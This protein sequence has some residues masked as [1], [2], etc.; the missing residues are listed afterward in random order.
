ML[1]DSKELKKVCKIKRLPSKMRFEFDDEKLILKI[2]VEKRSVSE[3][4][5]NNSAAFEGWIFC[6]L[7]K[8]GIEKVKV[9]ELDWEKPEEEKNEHYRRF[10]YRVMKMQNHFPW[11]KIAEQ[12][13]V[14]VDSFRK[15]YYDCGKLYL[16]E[17]DSHDQKKVKKES[18]SY[19]EQVFYEKDGLKNKYGLEVV[20][21]QLPV[22]VFKDHI[23][24]A[25]YVFT[26]GKSAID[27]W[28]IKGKDLYI[29]ELKYNNKMVGIISE[30]L[31]Y[32]WIMEDVMFTKKMKYEDKAKNND[33]RKFQN[34]YSSIG[35]IS[36]IYAVFLID[37]LHPLIDEK[38]I[39]II[40]RENIEKRQS[41]QICKYKPTTDIEFI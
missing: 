33:K 3:N 19:M 25:T 2:V 5:Q 30:T 31:F 15:E 6:L 18:E 9:V 21:R 11:F 28:G 36:N 1:I 20:G 8:L 35:K 16:N 37:E 38:V 12:R 39:E 26:G 13:Q 10:L 17:P 41:L 40:N 24:T 34:F 4:M 27:L 32:L 22:G 29:F 14:I 23:A 7:G